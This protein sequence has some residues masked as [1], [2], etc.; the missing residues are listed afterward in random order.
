MSRIKKAIIGKVI[1]KANSVA[2]IEFREAAV[3]VVLLVNGKVSGAGVVVAN[4][5]SEII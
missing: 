3:V 2:L 4:K 1:D 5:N